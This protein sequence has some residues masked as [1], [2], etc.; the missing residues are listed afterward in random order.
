MPSSSRQR[1]LPALGLG[2]IEQGDAERLQALTARRV[3]IEDCA[4][5]AIRPPPVIEPPT[6]DWLSGPSPRPGLLP[7]FRALL[8]E[9]RAARRLR[10]RTFLEVLE[11][12]GRARMNGNPPNARDRDRLLRAIAGAARRALY[13]ARAQDRCLVRALAVHAICNKNGIRPKLVFGVVAHPFAA[14]RLET[15]AA[16]FSRKRPG[17]ARRPPGPGGKLR[18][19]ALQVEVLTPRR[20][21]SGALKAY[22]RMRQQQAQTGQSRRISGQQQTGE[23]AGGRHAICRTARR[24]AISSPLVRQNP[25]PLIWEIFGKRLARVFYLP[26]SY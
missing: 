17:H 18:S 13:F 8:S 23:P 24:S 20:L 10:T 2:N 22:C 1:G 5:G 7:L 16:T 19:A 11:S 12:A 26:L 9:T 3:L 14:H 25:M 21:R 15:C 6:C 4:S